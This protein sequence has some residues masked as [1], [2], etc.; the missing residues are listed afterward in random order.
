MSFKISKNTLRELVRCIPLFCF[1]ILASLSKFVPTICLFLLVLLLGLQIFSIICSGKLYVNMSLF[2]VIGMLIIYINN[3]AYFM[4][5]SLAHMIYF[6]LF[7]I[8]ILFASIGGYQNSKWINLLLNMLKGAYIVYIIF[9]IL[10]FASR[11]VLQFVCGLFPE[12]AN[13]IIRQYNEAGIPGLTTHYSTNGMLLAVGTVIFGSYAIV[14]KNKFNIILFSFSIIALLLSGKRAHIVFGILAFYL[15]YYVYNSGKK[16]NRIIK[17]L[18]V[19]LLGTTVFVI[20]SYFVPALGTVVGRF[21][22][23]ADSGDISSGRI[24][25]W[26]NAIETI[27]S[28]TFIGIG[29]EQYVNQGG[30]FWNI[31]NIYLQLYIETGILGS[32]FYIGWFTFHLCRTWRLYS[33]MR[34][35]EKYYSKNDVCFIN[36]SL[37]MQILF[38]LYGFTGN[39]LYEAIMYVPYFIACAISVYYVKYYKPL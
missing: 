19:L 18:G 36:F 25:V 17:S 32:I 37:A 10:M 31:H 23:T 33:Y 8:C 30:W 11:S 14:K 26:M 21:I 27:S 1:C 35:N 7:P 15:T 5:N 39:P 3:N 6:L 12:E 28:H 29:W 38:L 24:D 34:I 2:W 16:K 22:D 9:T 20:A 13:T 4:P